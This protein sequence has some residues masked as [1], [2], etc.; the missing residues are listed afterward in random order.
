MNE[1]W[2]CPRCG[3]VLAPW[4]REC[5]CKVTSSPSAEPYYPEPRTGD[6]IPP[7]WWWITFSNQEVEF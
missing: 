3:K 4:I 2:I 5:D 1:G 6:P 7:N